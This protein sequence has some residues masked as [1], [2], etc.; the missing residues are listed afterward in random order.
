MGA[1]TAG[2]HIGRECWQYRVS[3]REAVCSG[4]ELREHQALTESPRP[5]TKVNKRTE[6]FCFFFSLLAI[7][8]FLPSCELQPQLYSSLLAVRYIHILICAT[9]TH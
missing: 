9:K 8:T 7:I 2:S 3:L 6:V 1:V 4:P 5:E